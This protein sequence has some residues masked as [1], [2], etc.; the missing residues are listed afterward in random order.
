MLDTQYRM[1][2]DI[3][4]FP[5]SEFYDLA[6]H[7]GTVDAFGNA[8]PGLEPPRSTHLNVQNRISKPSVIFVDHG[9]NESMKGR[10]RVNVTEAHLVASL[11]EDL[12]LVNK[13][14]RFSDASFNKLIIQQ[15]LQGRDIG[16]IAPYAAQITLLLRYLNNEPQYRERFKS[17]LGIQRAMQL[18]QI[19]VKTVDGFEG[20]EKEVIIFSTVRNNEGGHI[21]FL[22]DKKRLNV[23]LTRAKRGLFV[24]GS[25]STLKAGKPEYDEATGGIVN[26]SEGHI[27]PATIDDRKAR[28]VKKTKGRGH[29]SWQR[30]AQFMLDEN[31]VISLQGSNLFQVLYGHW[32]ALPQQ[33]KAEALAEGQ[34]LDEPNQR[35]RQPMVL[36]G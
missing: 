15:D 21:G 6:L 33:I 35:L 2:P 28:V 36:R 25:I 3:A 26:I 19:E 16:I 11:V 20:R 14:T 29:E 17:V 4:Q 1:H 22:A 30:Y 31:K 13:V 8:L 27:R 5:A 34:R 24:L 18:P 12:L 9:G 23:G 7:N 32:N 10:S